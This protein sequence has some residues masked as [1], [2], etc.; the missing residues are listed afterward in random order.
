MRKKRKKGVLT[1]FLCLLLSAML[2]VT[3]TVIE[4]VRI[5]GARIQAQAVSDSAVDSLFSEYYRPLWDNY[6]LL[7]FCGTYGQTAFSAQEV[8]A[9]MQDYM[10]ANLSPQGMGIFAAGMDSWKL[11]PGDSSLSACVLA[12]DADCAAYRRQAA[13]SVKSLVGEAFLEKLRTWAQEPFDMEALEDSYNQRTTDSEAEIAVQEEAMKQAGQQTAA[14]DASGPAD[15]AS[16]EG[17]TP[18]ES[19]QDTVG[20]DLEAPVSVP[21]S[22]STDAAQTE[23]NPIT[24][25]KEIKEKGILELV[26]PDPDALSD[27]QILTDNCVSARDLQTGI[28]PAEGDSAQGTADALQEKLLF[29]EYL[30]RQFSNAVSTDKVSLENGTAL[31]YELEY[32]LEGKNS[33]IRN[34]KGVAHKLLLMREAVNFAYLLTDESKQLQAETLAVAITGLVGIAPLA[35]A[36]RYGILLAWAYGESILDV[37]SLLAGGKVSLTKTPQTWQLALEKIGELVTRSG[38][39]T[40]QQENG[41]SYEMYLRLLLFAENETQLT[42]RSLDLIEK[43]MQRQPGGAYFEA[44]ALVAQLTAETKFSIRPLFLSFGFIQPYREAFTY[45]AQS[46]KSY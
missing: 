33:D 25:I 36:V 31:S 26:A 45:R 8:T 7:F 13:E 2:L 24:L 38:E 16:F 5:T 41:L 18:S 37:R 23:Y 1:V 34:L 44:D 21:A 40:Q 32:L 4:A 46:A 20:A 11:T 3:G 30:M 10:D 9:H 14:G 28:A 6:H 15:Q 17:G 12:T 22:P 35:S 27:K 39:E 42:L 19:I 43:N 29:H